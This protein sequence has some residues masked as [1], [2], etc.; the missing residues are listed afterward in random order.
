MGRDEQWSKFSHTFFIACPLY[1]LLPTYTWRFLHPPHWRGVL[2]DEGGSLLLHSSKGGFHA[3][4]S[5]VEA[6]ARVHVD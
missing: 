6:L 5:F 1:F 2:I 4:V 3:T